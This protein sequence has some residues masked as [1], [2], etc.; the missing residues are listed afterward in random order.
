MALHDAVYS[1][2]YQHALALAMVGADVNFKRPDDSS[3]TP[4]HI[5]AAARDKTSRQRVESGPMIEMLVAKGADP[6][7]EDQWGA[8][9][10]ILAVRNGFSG[11]V[12]SLLDCGANP[13]HAAQTFPGS[14]TKWTPLRWANEIAQDTRRE[15]EKALAM[16]WIIRR[17]RERGAWE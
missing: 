4:L 10:L 6:E 2:K 8:T 11:N 15:G 7:T 3:K 12:E 17:L 5:A 9:P 1:E 16:P 14:P 13:N